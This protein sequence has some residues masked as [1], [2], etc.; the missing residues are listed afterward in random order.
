MVRTLLSARLTPER[1][2]EVAALLNASSDVTTARTGLTEDPREASPTSG[3]AVPSATPSP[4][5]LTVDVVGLTAAGM[6]D[7]QLAAFLDLATR[8][9]AGTVTILLERVPELRLI[10]ETH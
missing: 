4:V 2:H 5:M 3:P 6:T 1:R 10:E 9:V 7:E 8:Q